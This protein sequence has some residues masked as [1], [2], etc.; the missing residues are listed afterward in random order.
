MIENFMNEK[1]STG[2][3]DGVKIVDLS[4]VLAGPFCTMLLADYGA[5]VIKVEQPGKG[6]GTRAWGPPWEGGES[7]YYLSINRNKQSITLNLKSEQGREILGRLLKDADVLVENFKPGTMD[8]LGLGYDVLQERYPSLVVCSITGFGQGGPYRDRPG[9]D[10][11]IQAMGGI[12]SISGPADGPPSKVG[13]AIVDITT[14][15]FASNAILAALHHRQQ[16]G[17]GQLIDV[18]LL[19]AQVGWLANVAHNYFA[20]GEMPKRYG[21]AHAN[22]VPYES[23]QTADG[24]ITLAVGTDGQFRRFC[25]A[26]GRPE[27][28]VDARFKSNADRVQNR[29]VLIS[30]LQDLFLMQDS[31]HWLDLLEEN[32]IPGGPIN[33]IPSILADPQVLQRQMVQEIEHP[34]AGIIKQIG[35]VAKLSGTPATIRQAPPLMGEQTELVL[36]AA[37]YSN[38]EIDAFRSDGV[39]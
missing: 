7:A 25:E 35:P 3:L 37:G 36:Q 34:T 27:M 11:M 20:S 15:L 12:M 6:D 16:T 14:G 4:R 19:D 29:T 31:K 2:A 22:V 18:A 26:A 28:G 8:R 24:H 5:E 23:F 32:N 1:F 10:F 33:D 9:Y 17:E 13:V 21:N 38:E 30:L 39:I